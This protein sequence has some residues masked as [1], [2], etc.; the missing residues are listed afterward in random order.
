MEYGGLVALIGA[1]STAVGVILGVAGKWFLEYF[2]KK[3]DMSV[4]QLKAEVEAKKSERETVFS[5]AMKL[6]EIA[7]KERDGTEKENVILHEKLIQCERAR[8]R[9]EGRDPSGSG[10]Q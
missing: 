4:V 5:E 10:I 6:I 3:S 2:Q 9:L 8:A 1:I 7:Q